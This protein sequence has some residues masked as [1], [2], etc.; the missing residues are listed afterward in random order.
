MSVQKKKKNKKNKNKMGET[1]P[2]NYMGMKDLHI[3]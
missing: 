1:Q 2:A 3:L